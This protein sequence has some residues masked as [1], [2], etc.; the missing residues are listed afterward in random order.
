MQEEQ[1][2]WPV[3]EFPPE[4]THPE[5][6]LVQA[7]DPKPVVAVDPHVQP[8]TVLQ[9]WFATEMRVWVTVPYVKLTV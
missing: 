1:D 7:G 5:T 9:N 8:L 3:H 2:I 4:A 6:V